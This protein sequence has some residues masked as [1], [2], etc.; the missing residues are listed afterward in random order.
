MKKLTALLLAL[1]LL[2]CASAQASA[3]LTPKPLNPKA[4]DANPYMAPGESNVHNDSY[5]SD[6]TDAVQPI[7][8]DAEVSTAYE[9]LNRY[10]APEFFMT[11]MA[12]P[13]P[14]CWAVWRS[15]T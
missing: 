9:R 12:I 1:A 6:V 3:A 13:S 7:G 14:R 10:A 5:N 8:I 15:A 2:G 4:M 11:H